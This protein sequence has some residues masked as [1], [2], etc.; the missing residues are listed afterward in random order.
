M[1]GVLFFLLALMFLL[2]CSNSESISAER[3]ATRKSVQ[4]SLDL[5]D[6]AQI[7]ALGQVVALGTDDSNA[8]P[9]ARPLMLVQFDYD[10]FI[11]N[12]EVT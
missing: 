12:H 1:K 11:G 4:D 3:E 6:M 2:G 8:L 10:Y 7:N 5:K 9:H